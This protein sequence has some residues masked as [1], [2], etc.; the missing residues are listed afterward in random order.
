MALYYLERCA[1][2]PIPE[3]STGQI[4]RY[5]ETSRENLIACLLPALEAGMVHRRRHVRGEEWLWS[6]KPQPAEDGY[7]TDRVGDSDLDPCNAL[8]PIEN[9]R[10]GPAAYRPREERISL[11]EP[12]VDEVTISL[13]QDGSL[14]LRRYGVLLGRFEKN[15]TLALARYFGALRELDHGD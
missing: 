8:L 12:D 3:Q 13:W 6:L 9:N 2:D 14:E 11:P 5:V 4:A 1:S 10:L 15:V 7:T